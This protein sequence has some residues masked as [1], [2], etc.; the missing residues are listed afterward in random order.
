MVNPPGSCPSPQ[1]PTDDRPRRTPSRARVRAMGV[2]ALL[3]WVL[4]LVATATALDARAG[5]ETAGNITTIS[6]SYA[7]DGPEVHTDATSIAIDSTVNGNG[8]WVLGTDGGVST[9]G[10]APFA[11]SAAGLTAFATDIARTPSGLGYWVV[12]ADGAVYAF[13]D[14]AYHGGANVFAIDE[15][16]ITIVPT[17]TGNGYWLFGVRGGVFSFGD[18]AFRGSAAG[19]PMNG[20]VTDAARDASGNGYWIVSSDGGVFSFGDAP[21]LGSAGGF[22]HPAVHAIVTPA[23]GD[24]YWLV[25][26]DGGVFSYGVPFLGSAAGRSPATLTVDAVARPA[27]AGYRL[28]ARPDVPPP[29]PPPPPPPADEPPPP[30]GG[31]WEALRNCE[32]GGDY[33]INSGNGFYG[34]YQ[35]SLGTWRA[36]GTGYDYPHEAPYWVQ[37]AA[38]QNLQARAGWGQWPACSRQLG[39][40]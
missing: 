9:Y 28:L 33:G 22:D 35:F 21:F 12:G 19:I 17:A 7:L 37:D 39:L 25:A 2:T 10:D 20:F 23:D 31:V 5:A 18:A 6:R 27:G 1:P 16:I 8:Y 38:A 32:S 3:A 30:A 4:A 13:G 15:G 11:G 26:A 29:P 14:A 36:M 24:G 40:R 34:A